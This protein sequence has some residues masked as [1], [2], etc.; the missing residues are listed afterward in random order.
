MKLVP[1]INYTPIFQFVK[2]NSADFARKLIKL[3]HGLRRVLI[4]FVEL[5]AKMTKRDGDEPK[6]DPVPGCEQI[7]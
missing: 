4:Q 5:P 2:R 6:S 1:I 3:P 7:I